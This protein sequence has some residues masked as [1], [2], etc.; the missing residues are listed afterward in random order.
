MELHRINDCC[1]IPLFEEGP[2]LFDTLGLASIP[3]IEHCLTVYTCIGIS[4][5]IQ[6]QGVLDYYKNSNLIGKGQERISLLF[7]EN[8]GSGNLKKTSDPVKNMSIGRKRKRKSEEKIKESKAILLPVSHNA[9]GVA[10]NVSMETTMQNQPVAHSVST[11]DERGMWAALVNK[12]VWSG[13]LS[14]NYENLNLF[15]AKAGMVLVRDG[16]GLTLGVV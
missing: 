15:L 10:T 13:G 8:T 14:E 1:S 7:N 16:C 5:N 6:H 11:M 12:K 2:V 4:D 9:M 3:P